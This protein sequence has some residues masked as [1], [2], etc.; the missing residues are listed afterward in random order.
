M[1]VKLLI[2]LDKA[3]VKCMDCVMRFLHI[4]QICHTAMYVKVVIASSICA[5]ESMFFELVEACPPILLAGWKE[6]SFNWHF[7]HLH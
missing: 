1:L 2:S 3:S 4:T 5:T 7:L 6:I